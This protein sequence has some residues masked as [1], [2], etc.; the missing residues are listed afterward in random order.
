MFP[1]RGQD[2]TIHGLVFNGRFLLEEKALF[3]ERK[4]WLEGCW[5]PLRGQHQFVHWHGG[6]PLGLPSTSWWISSSH[7]YV[8]FGG[9]ILSPFWSFHPLPLPLAPPINRGGEGSPKS[10][11]LS[12]TQGMHDLPSLSPSHEIVS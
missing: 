10:E 3:G 5:G 2:P 8:A 6:V 4:R 1:D 7:P 9:K 12:Q 11:N